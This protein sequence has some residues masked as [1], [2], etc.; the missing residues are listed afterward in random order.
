VG[1]VFLLLILS[2]CA[3]AIVKS[4][5]FQAVGIFRTQIHEFNCDPSR[6]ATLAGF[7]INLSQRPITFSCNAI[8]TPSSI[9]ITLSES[10]KSQDDFLSTIQVLWNVPDPISGGIVTLNSSLARSK[11]YSGGGY[12]FFTNAEQI[13]NYEYEWSGIATLKGSFRLGT[14]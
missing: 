7:P 4:G 12:N 13:G 11:S 3:P 5:T 9:T 8:N 6:A 1:L 10:K 14:Q 2:S